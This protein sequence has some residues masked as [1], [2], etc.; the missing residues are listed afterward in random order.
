MNSMIKIALVG[1]SILSLGAL[2]ACQSS[3][4][5]KDNDHARM[6]KDHHPQH[7]RKM[8]AEQREQFKQSRHERKQVFEQ[9]QKACDSKAAGTA[10]Q[11]QAGEKTLDGTCTMTFKPAHKA[12]QKMR[13]E[14][15]SMKDEH[16]PMRGEMGNAMHMQHD[17]PLTDARRAELTQQFAQRLAE[18]QAIQQAIA[19]A[20]QGQTHGKAIQIK[21]GVQT[22]DGQCE[23]RFQPK[24]PVAPSPAPVKS[25]L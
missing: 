15:R 19:K 1:T 20:C 18:R 13:G 2:T 25:A 7:E 5:V 22:I 21:V 6:M 8:T 3:H 10:V 4:S 17:E 11:I 9:I 24:A 23:I 12:S 16:R 14:Q